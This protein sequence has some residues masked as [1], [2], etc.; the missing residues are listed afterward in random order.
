MGELNYCPACGNEYKECDCEHVEE[1][2]LIESKFRWE[3][4]HE[5]CSYYHSQFR[6]IMPDDDC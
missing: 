2:I 1:D 4:Q 3:Y 5:M 6:K